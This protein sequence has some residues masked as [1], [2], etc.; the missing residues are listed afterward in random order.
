M[1]VPIFFFFFIR[2]NEMREQVRYLVTGRER[3][4]GREIKKKSYLL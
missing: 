2:T 3:E 1:L 4:G